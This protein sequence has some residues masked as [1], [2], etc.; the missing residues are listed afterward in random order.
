MVA[1]GMARAFTKYSSNYVGQEKQVIGAHRVHAHECEDL[2]SRAKN[3]AD[4]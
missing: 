3:Q 2:D 1:T 4:R